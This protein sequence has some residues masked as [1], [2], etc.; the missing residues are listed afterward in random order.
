MQRLVDRLPPGGRRRRAEQV[1]V[2][3]PGLLVSVVVALAAT[4]LS[5]HYGGPVMLFALL[6]GIA[7]NF[8]SS[9]RPCKPGIE[10]AARTILRFGVALLGVRITVSDAL[11]L[12][13]APLF[14]AIAGVATT[15]G[16]GLLLAR[17]LGFPRLFGLLTGGAVGICGASAALAIA[18]VLPRRDGVRESDVIFTVVVVTTLSTVAMVLYPILLQQTSLGDARMGIFLGATIHDVAQVVGAG[19]SISPETGDA[20]TLTKLLRVAMLV[21]VVLLISVI[22]SRGRSEGRVAVPGFLVGFVALVAV[23]SFGLVPAAAQTGLSDV[24]RWALVTAI[25]ALGMKTMLGQVLTVG[26]RALLLI[27]F[28]T[29]W[30][31]GV[32]LTAVV[33][34]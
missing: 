9:E 6:L 23:N 10:M 12:G 33:L 8:L 32:G 14:L 25:A 26:P 28:E 31:A 5:E 7:F 4:F 11:M 19:F 13:P 2:L 3:F 18:S 34:F 27:L 24:S 22:V 16:V 30:I 1:L 17:L 20:A 15:I 29:I 21:P